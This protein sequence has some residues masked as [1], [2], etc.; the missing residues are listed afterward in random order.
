[1]KLS[2][3][4]DS[5]EFACRCGCGFASVDPALVEG[6]ELLRLKIGHAVQITSGCRCR[7]RNRIVGGSPSSQHLLG[8]A[9]DVAV[10]YLTG[11]EIYKYAQT[12]PLFRGFGVGGGFLHVDV[13]AGA[14]ARWKY[15]REG[16]VVAWPE[17]RTA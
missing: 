10:P 7:E 9:A 12:I 5:S 3:H 17:S 1:M 4:F 11:E 2:A 6:L 14:A 8:R 13:R 15:D 16:R